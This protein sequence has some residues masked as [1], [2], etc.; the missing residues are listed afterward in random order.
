M[1]DLD[2]LALQLFVVYEALIHKDEKG[3][4]IREL[5]ERLRR[6]RKRKGGRID[7]GGQ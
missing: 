3:E 6:E 2:D 1:S 4:E 5:V 7:L